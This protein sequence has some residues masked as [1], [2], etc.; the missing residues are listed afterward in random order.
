[1][2]SHKRN[3]RVTGVWSIS[4]CSSL[5]YPDNLNSPMLPWRAIGV[6]THWLAAFCDRS[7]LPCG[8]PRP[9]IANE[10]E[11]EPWGRS[12]GL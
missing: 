12:D 5:Y 10:V 1:M 4:S 8:R 6:V 7:V 2:D 3:V 11:V 9:R